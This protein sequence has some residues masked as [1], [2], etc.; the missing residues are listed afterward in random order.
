MIRS[1]PTLSTTAAL[2]RRGRTS[3]V[4]GLSVGESVHFSEWDLEVWGH[5][6]PD[7]SG[8]SPLRDPPARTARWR[9]A[10]AHGQFDEDPP[11]PSA[12]WPS[13][14]IRSEHIVSAQADYVALG[15][16][17]RP[18][19]VGSNGA[20]AYYSGS[21]GLAETVNLVRLAPDGYVRVSRQPLRPPPS[22]S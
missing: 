7:Y 22:V 8:M 12:W 20:L 19:R 11:G 5:A 10:V 3:T 4:L 13:W 18:A 9:I 21:P 16:W 17:N 1:P 6:H 14:R 2:S 15:H